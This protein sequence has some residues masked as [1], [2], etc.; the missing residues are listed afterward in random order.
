VETTD[1]KAD[2]PVDQ[3]QPV[4]LAVHSPAELQV[5]V[6]LAGPP[7]LHHLVVVSRV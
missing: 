4:Q 5:K 1:K 7:R 3:V 6:E 2:E